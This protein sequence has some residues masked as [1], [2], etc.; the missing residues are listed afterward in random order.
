[1]KKPK[2][3]QGVF[4][5][6]I[7][8]D[9]GSAVI[10]D[11]KTD[12]QFRLTPTAPISLSIVGTVDGTKTAFTN[13]D[14]LLE[15]TF[16]GFHEFTQGERFTRQQVE[17]PITWLQKQ[18]LTR[19]RP[20]ETRRDI[21]IHIARLRIQCD[22]LSR[23]APISRDKA[24]E[25]LALLPEC[26]ELDF[27]SLSRAERRGAQILKGGALFELHM[28]GGSIVGLKGHGLVQHE[29]G[30][31]YR[32]FCYAGTGSEAEKFESHPWV[33]MNGSIEAKPLDVTL[34]VTV[35]KAVEGGTEF[36]V[37]LDGRIVTTKQV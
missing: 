4:P 6:N 2:S 36:I 12:D 34:K 15:G 25:K 28:D 26:P 20:S 29:W 9:Y 11:P 23:S 18:N 31:V 35:R 14:E 33:L 3:K 7:T 30:C 5:L 16:V 10:I 13:G 22:A 32:A 8:A 17:Q 1:M 19:G 24:M 37:E 27:D 21:G